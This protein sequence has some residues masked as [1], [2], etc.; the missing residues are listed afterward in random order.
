[1]TDLGQ[2]LD[3]MRR[4]IGTS[5]AEGRFAFA[6]HDVTETD[7]SV[8]AIVP[9]AGGRVTVTLGVDHGPVEAVIIDGCVTDAGLDGAEVETIGLLWDDA[10]P[11]VNAWIDT[12]R[13][14]RGVKVRTFQRV[15]WELIQKSAAGRIVHRI[16][17]GTPPNNTEF[18]LTG[19][20]PS[21]FWALSFL[22][23]EGHHA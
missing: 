3:A 22:D 18:P 20:E 4:T 8:E 2:M 13:A 12:Q 10:L 5:P 14:D 15:G 16:A 7:T 6:M 9:V 23:S 21:P 19:R 1:M 11:A 17:H